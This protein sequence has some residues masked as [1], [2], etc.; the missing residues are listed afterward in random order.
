MFQTE[1][2]L[3]SDLPLKAAACSTCVRLLI[4]VNQN[5]SWSKWSERKL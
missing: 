4:W 2:K 3:L 5:S 1:V